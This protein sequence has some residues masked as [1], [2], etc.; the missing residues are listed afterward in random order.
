MGDQLASNPEALRLFFTEDIYLVQQGTEES[1]TSPLGAVHLV[2]QSPET[3]ETN[4]LDPNSI[5]IQENLPAQLKEEVEEN[6]PL[7]EEAASSYTPSL[8]K[9]PIEALDQA[10]EPQLSSPKLESSFVYLGKNARNILILVY[11]ELNEVTTEAGREV[12]KNIV[13]AKS[14]SA[15]D[16]A[17]LNYASYKDSTFKELSDFFRA[18]AILTFGVKPL[19]LGITDYPQHTVITHEG[20]RMMFSADLQEL[21]MDTNI[22]RALWRA[23]KEMEL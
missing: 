8:T 22:K 11:D 9:T 13:K 17:I 10:D 2:P 15:N 6:L 14:L 18:K 23:L 16:Y 1:P 5:L 3:S 19:Q 21:S 7:V 12:F 20:V 4:A